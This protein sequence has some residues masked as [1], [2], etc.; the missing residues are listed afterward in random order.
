MEIPYSHN[1]TPFFAL[2]VDCA[3]SQVDRNLADKTTS[4]PAE[5]ANV[6][7]LI[8]SFPHFLISHFLISCSCFLR[9]PSDS[10]CIVRGELSAVHVDFS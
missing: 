7:F 1:L 6:H 9:Q 4:P 2:P 3:L 10:T 5:S 8:S